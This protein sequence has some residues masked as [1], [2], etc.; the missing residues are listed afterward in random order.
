MKKH[1][2]ALLIFAIAINNLS[3]AQYAIIDGVPRDT[4]FNTPLTYIKTKKQFPFIQIAEPEKPVNVVAYENVV[5]K[6]IDNSSIKNRSLKMNIYRPDDKKK[7]PAL[8]LIHGG[9]WSSGTYSMEV[10]MAMQVA[11]KGYV[12]IPVEYRLSPEAI[13]PA[14]VYDIK[15]AIKWVRKNAAKYNIDADHIA[16]SGTSAGGQLANLMGATNG[17]KKYEDPNDKMNVSSDVQAVIDIDG[18]SDFTSEESTT[19]ANQSKGKSNP[20]ADVKWLGGTYEEQKQTWIDASPIFH[21]SDK[22]APVCFINSSID[23]FHYGRDEMIAKLDSLHLYSEVH[24]FPDTPHPYWLFR[25]WFT[26]TVNYMASFLDKVF[27]NN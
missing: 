3:Q 2:F 17:L 23:R 15:S 7:Y 10:P 20:P 11:S 21:V 24:T 22:S 8:I 1:F 25:P 16:V 4:T 6:T 12:T 13:Y 19:R 9:G 14:A 5:Y 27:K 18:I 26:S